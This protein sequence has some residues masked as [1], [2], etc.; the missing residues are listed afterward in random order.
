MAVKI[1]TDSTADLPESLVQSLGITVVPLSV[2]FGRDTYLDGV[3]LKADEFYEKLARSRY[4]PTTSQPTPAA[5]T[6]VY[7]TISNQTDEILSI[8][9]SPKL[10]GTLNS[11]LLAREA[12]NSGCRIEI[13]D[14]LQASMGLGLIIIKA[15]EAVREGAGLEEALELTHGLIP[16]THLFGMVD[17]LEYLHKGGRIGRAQA[18]MGTLLSIKPLIGTGGGEVQPKGKAR[19]QKKALARLSEMVQGFG[20]IEEMTILHS[21]IPAEAAALT[22]RMAAVFEKDRIYQSRIGPVIGTYLGPGAI[23]IGVIEKDSHPEHTD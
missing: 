7:N 15:A 16:R 10:S 14:S 3:D 1:V 9:I 21:T 8:H 4:L 12:M 6:E 23:A 19:T 22:E 20:G 11:A 5:F 18:L 17:T 2:N 13:I